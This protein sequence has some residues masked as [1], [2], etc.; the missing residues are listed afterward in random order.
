MKNIPTILL[1]IFILAQVHAS[2]PKAKADVSVEALSTNGSSEEMESGTGVIEVENPVHD[3]GK[4]GFNNYYDCRFEFKNTGQG[5]LHISKIKSSCGC[6]VPE[7]DKKTYAPGESGTV[8]VKYHSPRKEGPVT[9][10]LY[11][12]SDDKKHPSTNLVI[13]A[14]VEAKV[15]VDPEKL[16]LSLRAEN[17]GL[18]SITLTSKDG[19]AF[20]IKK[21][22][23]SKNVI[24][25]DFDPELE[26]TR[27][28]LKPKVDL[29]KLK[30]NKKGTIIFYL[31]HPENDQLYVNFEAEA[32]FT[33]S[34]QHIYISNAEPGK[35]ITKDIWV[36]SKYAEKVNI[37]SVTSKNNFMEV[38]ARQPEA[39]RIKLRVRITPPAPSNGST[40]FSDELRIKL[41]NGEDLTVRCKG[42]L[43][44]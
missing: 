32:S 43:T 13:K 23:V 36:T 33:V 6:A 4:V 25:L 10:Y 26:A 39:D 35:I 29:E 44:K 16:E 8:K 17:A 21:F 28:V 14:V 19:R 22:L 20:S 30:K 34:Q 3:F 37:E 27:F 42:W 15:A 38:I 5:P 31:T 11:I 41:K 7:L 1:Y 2:E 18:D 12:L 9:K 24:T 40:Y